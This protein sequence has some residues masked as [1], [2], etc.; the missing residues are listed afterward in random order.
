VV[1]AQ[2]PSAIIVF[3]PHG[4]QARCRSVPRDCSCWPASSIFLIPAASLHIHEGDATTTGLAWRD[5]AVRAG[6]RFTR[7]ALAFEAGRDGLK[8]RFAHDSLVEGSGF[9]PSV[10]SERG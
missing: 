8:I 5:E 6:R 2:G 3:R 9:E 7:I 1:S 10:P 4:R